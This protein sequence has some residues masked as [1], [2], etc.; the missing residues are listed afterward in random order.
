MRRAS[1]RLFQLSLCLALM[2][3]F[4]IIVSAQFKAGIQGTVTDNNGG[5]VP[6]ATVTLTNIDT[7]RTEKIITNNSGFYRF[8][9]L[10]PGK[11]TVTTEKEGFKKSILDDVVI[12]AEQIQGLDITLEAG[13][14]SETVTV[15]ADEQPLQTEDANI[16][17]SITTKEVLALPQTGRDPYSLAR[18]APG[19]FGDNGANS[20]GSRVL[21]PNN[22]TAGAGS[23]NDIFSTENQPQI[24]ANGQ[25]VT[26][27][28]Y[29]VDGTS[30][31]SQTWGGAAVITPSQESVKEVVVSASTYS[32]EDGRNSGAQIKVVTQNGTNQWHGS[33]FFKLND[34]SLNAFNKFPR[35]IGT[36]QVEGPRRVERKFKTYG[37]SFGGPIARDRL[38]FFFSYEAFKQSNS[39]SY[40]SYIDTPEFRQGIISARSGTV[41]AQLLQSAGVE[42]RVLRIIPTSCTT[43]ETV[44][45]NNVT[46]NNCRTVNG[47]LD[48][49]SVGGTYGNYL[50]NALEPVGGGFD[51]VA[52]LQYAELASETNSRG[53]QFFTRI[54]WNVTNKDKLA[55]SS[56]FVPT[57]AFSTDSSAQSRPV[58][59]LTTDRLNYAVGIIYSRNISATMVNEA[60]F[61]IT[62]W[63]FNEFES[64]PDLDFGLP[65]VEIEQIFASDRLRYGA[66]RI[67]TI[68]D[69]KQLDF[70]DTLT[71][72]V[73]N[74][75]L[76]FGGEF[77]KDLNGNAQLGLG[78][79]LFTFV[80]A[81]NFA[82]GTPIFES[83]ATDVD[84]KPNN[85][86][87][88]FNT[89]ELAFFAQD[90]WKFRP[91]L[92]LN[93][94]LRWSY[95]APIAATDGVLGNLQPD[96]NGQLGGAKIV[97]EETLY[98]KDFNNFG[99][100]FGFAWSPE[101]FN[102][103]M[104]IRGG[105]G[106]GYDRLPNALLANARRNPPNG[107]NFGFCCAN[108]G[109]PFLGGRIAFVSSTDGSITG[110]P[111]NPL[112]GGVD[113]A[114]GL[115]LAGNAEIY[116]AP[117]DFPTA[118]IIRYSL[119]GQYELPAK[120]VGTLG[121]S[122]SQGHHFV[123][124]L[125][126]HVTSPT[127]NP[128]L[129]AVFFASPD[130]NTSYHAMLARLQ[131]RLAKQFSFDA[132]YRFSKSI[133][134]VSF[135]GACGC[136]NQSF[137]IDQSQERG[138]SDFDVR[139]YFVMTGIWE[140]P[141]F[142]NPWG[143]QLFGGWQLSGI[144]TYHTGFPWTPKINSNANGPSGRGFGPLRPT[145]Y[146]G[147]QPLSNTNENFL[148]PFGIFAGN[149][150]TTVFGTT[151]TGN[152]FQQN[153]P[154][155]GRNTF[156]G[157]RYFSV[158]M[159]IAKKFTFG[160]SGF[161]GENAQVDVRFNFFNI[162]NT[163]N[164]LPFNAN[165]GPV[166]V[167][168]AT[169]ATP[170]GGQAGRV[171]EFQIRFSF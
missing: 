2:V 38:F 47:G 146:N 20:G 67:T 94:G 18:T 127:I 164:L 86:G 16:R 26:S 74:H 9:A 112:L 132:N 145:S 130:V 70:R 99:P 92:T 83:I 104:V 136:T 46:R 161:F 169:F 45:L 149:N 121:Y 120:M 32:A 128:L 64:N 139:H 89:S 19:V 52:D 76:K 71:N 158:D 100:Q 30:V 57:S 96:A 119:E 40:F 56:F 75:V 156:R 141:Y 22:G 14:I 78:R 125:P 153:P 154:A 107:R 162:F 124:I 147:T 105:G 143:R 7:N 90:D 166:T 101:R 87:A 138:P 60:R 118:Y 142:E 163:L 77:R 134:T 155:I 3:F 72:I 159:A 97:T 12:N 135:E 106:I 24:S 91:N 168:N 29:Q 82:N 53:Q 80:R 108:A 123:R 50:S 160:S 10:A 61:N 93:L 129:G 126:F 81:W 34:P 111:A 11:Y 109:D 21:L 35:F 43:F 39:G 66:R 151:V 144:A 79:P 15:T 85:P 140:I 44:A 23:G 167:T 113:A 84:G 150:P 131:G 36:R 25:R 114:S 117:R 110:Y 103:K 65:R 115:P 137:P 152:T 42:P 63:G 95:F 58:S 98:D 54:D 49:G 27:N 17:K 55:F 165:S 157:P 62:S 88:K 59:D 31:N 13:A 1:F 8:S 37:G 28:N 102:S 68:F 171:G 51:G 69:E 33:A 170:T 6:G 4:S 48:I 5:V 73:G 133:D 41:T 148:Q 122:G 116:G